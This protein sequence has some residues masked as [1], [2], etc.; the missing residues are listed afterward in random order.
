MARSRP[1]RMRPGLVLGVVAGLAGTMPALADCATR[2]TQL[3]G[4]LASSDL[5][6]ATT[7][8]EAIKS[9]GACDR[10]QVGAAKKEVAAALLREAAKIQGVPERASDYAGLVRLAAAQDVFYVASWRLGDIERSARDYKAAAAAYQN[11][12]ELLGE[13]VAERR[14]KNVDVDDLMDRGRE[15]M[16]RAEEA[17]LLAAA[18]PEPQF[19]AAPTNHRG[20]LGGAYNP[21]FSTVEMRG[22]AVE[23]VIS[24]ITFHYD[25][26][27]FTPIGVEAAQELATL[28]TERRP[29]RVRIIGH[30]DQTGSDDYNLGLSLRRAEAV[31]A[32][33][34]SKGIGAPVSAEGKGERDPRALSAAASY[35]QEEI[36]ALNRRVEVTLD[37]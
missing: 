23:R 20:V 29:S 3:T 37:P 36:D 28:I 16:R 14:R 11:S 12:I 35:S 8:L 17:R 30:T 25:S 21:T 5:L 10:Y 33:L 19:A 26:T 6:R 34:K 31:A 4:L 2:M 15:L 13:D 32:F 27:S 18:A 1:S 22:I 9:D 24:P 7:V